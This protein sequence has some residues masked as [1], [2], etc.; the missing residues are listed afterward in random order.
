MTLRLTH[1]GHT[2]GRLSW[3]RL[4]SWHISSW[5]QC[6]LGLLLDG[7]SSYAVA[8]VY[9]GSGE[10]DNWCNGRSEFC[11]LGFD[12]FLFAGSHNA[13]TGQAEGTKPCLFKNQDLNF[14]EQLLFGIR[15]FDIDLI[16]T[17]SR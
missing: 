15:L 11:R 10:E 2:A 14:T 3:V 4:Y 12:R 6:E 13:G 5:L 1:S 9:T 7:D 17:N 16:Y 8:C